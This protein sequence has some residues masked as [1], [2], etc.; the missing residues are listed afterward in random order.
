MCVCM[1]V[2]VGRE[3]KAVSSCLG[4]CPFTGWRAVKLDGNVLGV[5]VAPPGLVRYHVR[6]KAIVPLQCAS[7]FDGLGK[8]FGS[9]DKSGENGET[10]HGKDGEK[11]VLPI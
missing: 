4:F 11:V 8:L 9:S 3:R 5:D 1:W 2:G 6:D 7:S 10:G